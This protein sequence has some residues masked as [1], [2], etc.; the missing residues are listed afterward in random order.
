[1]V[2]LEEAGHPWQGALQ[3]RQNSIHLHRR[4][5]ALLMFGDSPLLHETV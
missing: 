3:G 4:P 5:L 1:M 2:A